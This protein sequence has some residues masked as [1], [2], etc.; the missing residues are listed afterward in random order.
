MT[1]C[2]ARHLVSKTRSTMTMKMSGSS[3][4][5]FRCFVDALADV[6]DE[7]RCVT[8]KTRVKTATTRHVKTKTTVT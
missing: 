5:P 7:S 2:F 6:D 4:A 1:F 8:G 3:A